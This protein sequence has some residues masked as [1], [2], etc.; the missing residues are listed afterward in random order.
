MSGKK[1]SFNH[2]ALPIWGLV[3]FLSPVPLLIVSIFICWFLFFGIGIGVMGYEN[4][5]EWYSFLTILP[6]FVTA[7]LHICSS[8]TAVI[9]GIIR[10][11][12]PHA[13]LCVVLSALAIII[14]VGLWAGILYAGYHY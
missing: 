6:A 5:P 7:I 11:K 10:R 2:I 1:F 12:E 13:I 9:F 8:V 4:I 14:Q 3:N